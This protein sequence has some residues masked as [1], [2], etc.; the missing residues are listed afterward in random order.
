M[1]EDYKIKVKAYIRSCSQTISDSNVELFVERYA[2]DDYVIT[3][4]CIAPLYRRDKLVILKNFGLESI[5]SN[6]CGPIDI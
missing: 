3:D 2:T 1:P 5:L 4:P 6:D